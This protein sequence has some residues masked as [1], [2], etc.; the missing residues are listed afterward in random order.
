MLIVQMYDYA[1]RPFYFA[2][3][4]EENAKGIFARVLTYLVLFMSVV[5]LLLTLF[6]DDAVKISVF[7]RHLI[8][9]S[10]WSGLPLVP[11]VLCGYLFLGIYTNVSAGIYIQK[12]T[13]YLPFITIVGAVVNIAANYLLI[14]SMGMIGAAWATFFAYLGMAMAAYIVAQRVYPV[15]YEWNRILKIFLSLALVLV[16]YYALVLPIG[17]SMVRFAAKLTLA[18]FFILLMFALKFFRTTEVRLLRKI[19]QKEVAASPPAVDQPVD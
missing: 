13:A 14:P 7:G 10:Y 1:W 12:K 8:H 9:P 3:A 18:G 15:T 2:A 16:I 5:F 6:I 17:S 11:I 4:Q 19:F